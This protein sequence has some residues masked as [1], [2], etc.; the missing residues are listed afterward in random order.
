MLV[1]VT[2]KGRDDVVAVLDVAECKDR[3]R[4][5]SSAECFTLARTRPGT[6]IVAKMPIQP[7]VWRPGSRTPVPLDSRHA[8]RSHAMVTTSLPRAWPA[9]MVRR[10][11]AV[12]ARG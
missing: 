3:V 7:G 1:L 2:P 10:P 5:G 6:P 9:S 11:S 4:M 8:C 12:L